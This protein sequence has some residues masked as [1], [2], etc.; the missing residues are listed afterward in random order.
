MRKWEYDV[1]FHSLE[2]LG[3]SEEDV[4]FPKD[5]IISCDE[6][7]HCY[8]NDVMKSYVDVFRSAL[9]RKGDEGWELL[10]LEYHRSSLICF[11]KRE[12]TV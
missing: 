8:F 3:I 7:G 1:S 6:E 11:W 9:N 2:D 12:V 5:Q 4:D 10:Q